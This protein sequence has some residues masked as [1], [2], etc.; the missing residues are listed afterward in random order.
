[1]RWAPPNF[2]RSRFLLAAL[3][4]VPTLAMANAG[5]PLM[6]TTL[7]HLFVWNLFFG[8]VEGTLLWLMFRPPFWRAVILL[9]LANYMSAW[10][11][12]LVLG[13]WG[14]RA[15][16]ENFHTMIPSLVILAFLFTLIVEFPFVLLSFPRRKGNWLRA[17][18][19]VA[20]INILTYLALFWG[21]KNASD[22]SMISDLAL[23]PIQ[24][25]QAPAGYQLYYISP[26]RTRIMRSDLSGNEVKEVGEIQA[27][28][29]TRLLVQSGSD[30]RFNLVSAWSEGE[31]NGRKPRLILSDFAA[32]VAPDQVVRPGD[33][34]PG[35]FSTWA[36]PK[37]PTTDG[38]AYYG[39]S[40]PT[41]GLRCYNESGQQQF[42]YALSSVLLS[43]LVM[44]AVRLEENFLVF[45]IA[46]NICLL[47]PEKKRMAIITRGWSPLVVKPPA[48]TR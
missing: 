28:W 23:V 48:S 47:Q 38:L 32:Q 2:A 45:Q 46:G 40:Y 27:T 6:W 20:P 19:A 30:R 9:V 3:L 11:G 12:M 39:G 33:E 8:L 36:F 15:T 21:Y 5:T 17:L 44:D 24:H 37:F 42:H 1:M 7:A 25:M 26:D 10:A 34:P 43:A 14:P 22:T 31:K 16:L 13:K 29:D 4:L 18:I 41:D 35:R